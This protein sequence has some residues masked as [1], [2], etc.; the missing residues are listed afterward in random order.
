[1]Q[2][3]ASYVNCTEQ[4]LQYCRFTSSNIFI[5]ND[6][7]RRRFIKEIDRAGYSQLNTM[8]IVGCEG[9]TKLSTLV[10]R[11]KRIHSR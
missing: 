8:G 6:S 1:M 3:I 9:P 10:R 11:V 5:P 2:S 7:L 4:D